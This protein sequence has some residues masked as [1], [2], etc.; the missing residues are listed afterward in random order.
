M[1]VVGVRADAEKK[2]GKPIA[3]SLAHVRRTSAGFKDGLRKTIELSGADPG[4]A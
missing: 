1:V 2:T 3:N 4:P